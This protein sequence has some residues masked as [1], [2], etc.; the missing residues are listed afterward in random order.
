MIETESRVMQN[1]ARQGS[2]FQSVDRSNP[3]CST[4]NCK[5]SQLN[6]IESKFLVQPLLLLSTVVDSSA[7]SRV[8]N[9]AGETL[10]SVLE[11]NSELFCLNDE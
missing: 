6:T 3:L 9:L 4:D 11:L 10:F 8:S 1:S 2:V 7:D 5:Q